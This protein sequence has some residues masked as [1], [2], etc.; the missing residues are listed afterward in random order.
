MKV[1]ELIAML[2]DIDN[3]EDIRDYEVQSY[4]MDDERLR[5]VTGVTW[6]TEQ[7]TLSLHTDEL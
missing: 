7:K 1:R 3:I 4:D 5:S 2:H 6:S